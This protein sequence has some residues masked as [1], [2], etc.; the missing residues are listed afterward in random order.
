[1]AD[2]INGVYVVRKDHIISRRFYL[3]F[4]V[5][6]VAFIGFKIYHIVLAI[7]LYRIKKKSF[8]AF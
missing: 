7:K 2:D 8:F 6:L 3:F 5:W 4:I 1:M